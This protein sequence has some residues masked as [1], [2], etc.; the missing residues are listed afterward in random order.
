MNEFFEGL[1]PL[2][3]MIFFFLT[4]IIVYFIKAQTDRAKVLSRTEMQN[5]MID[6]FA[7]STEFVTFLRSRE[8]QQFLAGSAPAR[9][10]FHETKGLAAMRW[11]IT[12][13]VLGIGMCLLSGLTTVWAWVI[14]GTLL[15]S[16]GIGLFASG[17]L[18]NR[19][20]RSL[21]APREVPPVTPSPNDAVT[22]N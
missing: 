5:R 22:Q 9:A 1:I 16:L 7:T 17:L 11:G 10:A 2:A 8:G 6:K 4:V 18:S 13:G 3:G 15:L 20:A 21:A 19:V 14:P 12:F